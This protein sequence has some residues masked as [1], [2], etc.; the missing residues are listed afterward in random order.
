MS[1]SRAGPTAPSAPSPEV[2]MWQVRPA[3]ASEPAVPLC[4]CL[5]TRPLLLLSVASLQ[6][7]GGMP[8]HTA[9]PVPPSPASSHGPPALP[10]CRRRSSP[11]Q[12]RGGEMLKSRMKPGVTFCRKRESEKVQTARVGGRPREA[13][14]GRQSRNQP[15]RESHGSWLGQERQCPGGHHCPPSPR[16]LLAASWGTGCKR[17][18]LPRTG[19][20]PTSEQGVQAVGPSS[21]GAGS[22]SP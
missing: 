6:S 2:G 7:R 20:P 18:W 10:L 17:D 5:N 16:G 4:A 13:L 9:S 14:G 8:H 19:D 21:R 22:H 3:G 1:S 11:R 15:A 12:S